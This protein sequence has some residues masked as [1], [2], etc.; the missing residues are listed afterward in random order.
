MDFRQKSP[1]KQPVKEK[2]GTSKSTSTSGR[3]GGQTGIDSFAQKVDNPISRRRSLLQIREE[4]AEFDQS[5]WGDTDEEDGDTTWKPDEDPEDPIE[6]TEDDEVQVVGVSSRQGVGAGVGAGVRAGA[7]AGAGSGSGAGVANRLTSAATKRSGAVVGAVKG[8]GTGG[9][10]TLVL[11]DD[12][13][14]TGVVDR[15]DT[16]SPVE[17]CFAALQAIKKSVSRVR[18]ARASRIP[19][20]SIL[21]VWCA[22]ARLSDLARM[23]TIPRQGGTP[24]RQRW[25]TRHCR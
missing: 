1:R 6:L 16:Q 2:R 21:R 19:V 20:P 18:T 23:L 9:G 11:D 22:R 8:K 10:K 17:K 7:G 24:R 12:E 3:K 14:E 15:R 25:R 4:E 13:E 5:P